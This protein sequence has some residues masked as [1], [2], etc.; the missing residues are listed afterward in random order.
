MSD[1][2]TQPIIAA[3]KTWNHSVEWGWCSEGGSWS[4]RW[5]DKR[6][7]RTSTDQLVSVRIGISAQNLVQKTCTSKPLTDQ[8]RSL[9]TNAAIYHHRHHE[10]F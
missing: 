1:D 3:R 2:V 6:I 9:S 5:R 7:I 10:N 4:Q 8:T